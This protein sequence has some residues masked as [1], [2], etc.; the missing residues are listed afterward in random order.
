MLAKTEGFVKQKIGQ[1]PKKTLFPKYFFP[2]AA[3]VRALSK[4]VRRR[5]VCGL[6]LK[7]VS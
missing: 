7:I 2:T 5:C 4:K 1:N 3:N 6:C